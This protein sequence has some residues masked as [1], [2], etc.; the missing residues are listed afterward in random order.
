MSDMKM[1]RTKTKI[2]AIAMDILARDIQSDDGVANAAISEAAGR[3]RELDKAI[4][5]T[6]KENLHLADGKDC[7]LIKLKRAIR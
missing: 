5:E 3:L 1:K 7:T 2:L 6:L 4:R